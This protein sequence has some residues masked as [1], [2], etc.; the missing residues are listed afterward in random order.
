MLFRSPHGLSR[1]GVLD[2]VT[3]RPVAPIIAHSGNNNGSGGGVG[4]CAP[5]S[6]MLGPES[7]LFR[8]QIIDFTSNN[9]DNDHDGN[10]SNANAN[11]LGGDLNDSAM[12]LFALGG[13]AFGDNNNNNNSADN[14]NAHAAGNA[15]TK[16]GNEAGANVGASVNG[17]DDAGLWLLGNGST[18]ANR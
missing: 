6:G 13:S 12:G 11:S 15:N 9:A 10:G 17:D 8:S 18:N 7:D 4:G 14:S 3:I 2:F 16:A 1:G 5:S